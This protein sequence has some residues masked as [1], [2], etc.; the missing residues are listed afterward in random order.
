MLEK[1]IIPKV[2]MKQNTIRMRKWQ[3][4]FMIYGRP[5]L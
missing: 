3:N 2:K 4:F 1:Q 5:E